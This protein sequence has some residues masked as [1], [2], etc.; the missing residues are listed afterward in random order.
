MH[1][2]FQNALRIQKAHSEFKKLTPNSKAHSVSFDFPMKIKKQKLKNGSKSVFC[3]H[4][5]NEN[6]ILT[7]F[8][9]FLFQNHKVENKNELVFQLAYFSICTV[10]SFVFSMQIKKQKMEK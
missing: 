1:S 10:R 7:Q 4:M 9:L 3:L 6:Q 8:F 5:W 2:E